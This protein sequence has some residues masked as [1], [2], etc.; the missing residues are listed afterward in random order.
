MDL[1]KHYTDLFH[2]HGDSSNAVQYSD[3]KTQIKRFEI[4]K[5]IDVKLNSVI[6]IGCGLGHLYDYLSSEQSIDYL[7]LDFVEEFIHQANK[8]HPEKNVNFKTF[9][10]ITEEIPLNYDYIMLSGVFNN[11]MEDN[12]LFMKNTLKKM[13]NSANKGISFNAMST[14]V[15]YQDESL[16]Y[17]NPCKVFDFCKTEFGAKRITLRNDYLVK[18]NS[19]PFEFAMYIYK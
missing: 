4:L 15:D 8:T 10:I 2:E 5:E 14:Y 6:D 17:V 12:W 18:E 11:K 7:G 13:Y 19:V 3:S 16:F 1:K 9:D